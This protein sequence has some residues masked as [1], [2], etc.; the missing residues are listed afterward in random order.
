M[1][2]ECSENKDGFRIAKTKV[3]VTAKLM[4]A[5]VFAYADFLFSHAAAYISNISFICDLK[6]V[7]G[8]VQ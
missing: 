5:F 7:C 2:F 6:G 8:I 4:C 1:G 3:T